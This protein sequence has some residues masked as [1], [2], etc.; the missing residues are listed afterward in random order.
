MITPKLD[1][2][3]YTCS[4]NKCYLTWVSDNTAVSY[5][6]YRND[7]LLDT[8]TLKDLDEPF[9][10]LRYPRN[11]HLRNN[12]LKSKMYV[13]ETVKKFNTYDYKIRAVYENDEYSS[14]SNMRYVRCE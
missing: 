11:K 2:A 1:A 12:L 14:Y 4:N 5:E 8:V 6:I 3:S 9:V 13:D 7:V 10:F